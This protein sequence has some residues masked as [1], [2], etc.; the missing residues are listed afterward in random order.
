[1]RHAFLI[2]AHNEPYILK[3]LLEKLKAIRGNIYVH[4]DKKVHGEQ[5][6]VLTDVIQK[7]G[8]KIL[9]DRIDV[10]WGD[11]SQVECELALFK[12]AVQGRYDYYHLLSGVD[13]PIK[14]SDYITTFF[15]MNRGKEFFRVADDDKNRQLAYNNTNYY[16]VFTK[17]NKTTF[18]K[19]IRKLHIPQVS[20][21]IQRKFHISRCSKDSLPLYKGDNWMS[22]TDAAV[23][24]LLENENY[25][26]QRFKYTNCSDEIYKQTVLMNN[27]FGNKRYVASMNEN[28]AIRSIDW[29]RGRPY[30]WTMADLQELLE[31]GNLFARKFSTA[32]DK[33]IIN[34]IKERV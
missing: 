18:G 5:L 1:M 22:I 15:D 31:S 3:V 17:S 4:L 7:G 26:R 28:P 10:R 25:I 6:N 30:T 32:K 23:H 19:A 9:S 21:I 27:G 11:F 20:I 33:E 16:Y 12:E 29:K 14:P 24:C 2:I 34:Y 8:G 13:L